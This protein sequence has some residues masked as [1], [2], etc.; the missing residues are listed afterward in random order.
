[1]ERVESDTWESWTTFRFD[2][3]RRSTS[4]EWDLSTYENRL[5]IAFHNSMEYTGDVFRFPYM[6]PMK[7]RESWIGHPTGP[8]V[9]ERYAI[10]KHAARSIIHAELR[11]LLMK[12][13]SDLDEHGIDALRKVYPATLQLG[14]EKGYDLEEFD[15]ELDEVSEPES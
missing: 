4:F 11:K 5:G 6:R 14:D 7:P 15:S 8:P 9:S 1:M 3:L 12:W 13:K 2:L 10:A